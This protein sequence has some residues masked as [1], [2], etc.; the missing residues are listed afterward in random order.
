M[1]A[2]AHEVV[3]GIY[4]A[5]KAFVLTFSQSPQSELGGRGIYVQV[6][7]QGATRTRD[8]APC[9]P[10]TSMSSAAARIV[11]GFFTVY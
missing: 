6:V 3:P 1:L 9:G 5:T 11:S 2:L 4:P 8:L 7:L 10:V